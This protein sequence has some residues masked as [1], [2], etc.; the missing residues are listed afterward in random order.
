MSR[1]NIEKTCEQLVEQLGGYNPRTILIIAGGGL[2]VGYLLGGLA[3]RALGAV[4]LLLPL[5]VGL[6]AAIVIVA[7]KNQLTERLKERFP[8]N[9][10]AVQAPA[11]AP[12]QRPVTPSVQQRPAEPAAVELSE[13]EHLIMER[14]T[15]GDGNLSVSAIAGEAGVS[16]DD[17]RKAIEN[18][19]SQGLIDLG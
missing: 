5:V 6:V 12:T 13:L 10:P 9:R 15:Q 4:Y 2:G 18:L 3:N 8:T 14:V 7:Q 16:G 19:A 11:S 1:D 17:V